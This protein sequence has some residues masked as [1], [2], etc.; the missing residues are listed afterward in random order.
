MVKIIK[1]YKN[2]K[3]YDTDESHYITLTELFEYVRAG[4]DVQVVEQETNV[5]I[6]ASILL[7]ALLE[8]N[9]SR[10]SQTFTKE[11]LVNVIKQ[12]D[13]SLAGYINKTVGGV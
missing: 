10:E 11:M 9:K 5:D 7:N 6:T 3:L 12:G 2:R 4:T 8:R 13:G 1:R